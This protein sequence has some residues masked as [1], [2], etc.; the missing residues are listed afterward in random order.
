MIIGVDVSKYNLGWNPDKAIES[1]G[2]VIQRASW[3]LYKDEAFDKL[4]P[5]VQ[6]IPIRGAYHYYSSGVPWVKQAQLFLEIIKGK[7]FHFLVVDYERSFNTLSTRTIAEVAEMVKYIRVASGLRCMVYFS[8]SIYNESIKP[9]GYG[10]WAHEQDIWIA[11]YPWT[12]TQTPLTSKPNIPDGLPWRIWQY[13][14]GDVNYTAGRHAGADYGGGLVGMDLNYWNGTRE[15]MMTWAGVAQDPAPVPPVD[16]PVATDPNALTVTISA[17][18]IRPGAGKSQP[19]V[20]LL[21]KGAVVTIFEY[22][23]VSASEVW[24]R[25]DRGWICLLMGNVPYTSRKDF[26]GIVMSPVVDDFPHLYKVKD[27]IAAGVEPVGTRPFVRV[28]LPSTVRLHGIESQYSLPPR[29]IAYLKLINTPKAYDYL[30][31]PASGWHNQGAYNVMQQLTFSGNV[32]NVTRIE[33]ERAYIETYFLDQA[34]PKEIIKPLEKSLHPL[35]Q[36]FSTQYRNGLDMST[37][38]RYPR[39][40]II[41]NPGEEIWIDVRDIVRI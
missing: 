7:G 11:Q 28:G 29:W 22:K 5:E 35:V 3:S 32:V 16:P 25:I 34:P 23:R 14:G 41:A 31:K 10:P 6:K 20:G 4:L 9:Y 21:Y 40:L 27:D 36:M 1:I 2:F 38:M 19:P 33:G 18:N 13:G 24:G 26:T 37:N 39:T 15:E 8:P 30:I 17:L 12:L